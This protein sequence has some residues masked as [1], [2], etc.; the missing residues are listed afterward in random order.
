MVIQGGGWC[1]AVA[2]FALAWSNMVHVADSGNPANLWYYSV[3]AVA[4]AGACLARLKPRGLAFTLF[5]MAAHRADRRDAPFGRTA[6][7]RAE[8]GHR[9]WCLRGLFTAAGLLFRHA[10]WSELK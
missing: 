8:Y 2:M 1:G 5:A 4:G 3:L 6:L 7:P 10:S 9:A